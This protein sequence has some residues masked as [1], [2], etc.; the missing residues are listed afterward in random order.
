VLIDGLIRRRLH[1]GLGRFGWSSCERRESSRQGK[2]LKT[3]GDSP[4]AVKAPSET[5]TDELIRTGKDGL[6]LVTT[7]GHLSEVPLT[8]E[9]LDL[10]Y[11]PGG[12]ALAPYQR[13]YSVGTTAVDAIKAL[14]ERIGWGEIAVGIGTTENDLGGW[15]YRFTAN[16]TSMKA[17]GR[18]VPGGAILDWWK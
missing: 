2:R 11:A 3:I 9:R 12:P 6:V 16:G 4:S 8:K 17:G 5:V 1:N 13:V 15:D 7:V 10:S 18:Y 14:G